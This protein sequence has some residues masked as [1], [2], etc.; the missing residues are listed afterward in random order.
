MPATAIFSSL[1]ETQLAQK[2]LTNENP[3]RMLESFP[4][5]PRYENLISIHIQNSPEIKVTGLL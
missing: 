1:H 5:Y 4:L 2:I 3:W